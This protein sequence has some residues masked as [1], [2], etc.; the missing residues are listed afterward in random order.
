MT[1]EQRQKY[2]E[3]LAHIATENVS[4]KTLLMN[5]HDDQLDFYSSMTDSELMEEV[6]DNDV[7][8]IF[9]E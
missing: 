7:Q 2:I 8:E 3:Q 6:I 5:Y 1:P 4:E 9:G